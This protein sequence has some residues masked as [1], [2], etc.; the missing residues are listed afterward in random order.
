MEHL[1]IAGVFFWMAMAFFGTR[2]AYLAGEGPLRDLQAGIKR[3]SPALLFVIA[4][5]AAAMAFGLVF[6]EI[7]TVDQ[8]E[9]VV[10]LRFVVAV[11]FGVVGSVCLSAQ[12]YPRD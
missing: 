6:S 7:A 8:L 3:R 2:V 12:L 4:A 5:I 10:G 9:G 1:L 11:A